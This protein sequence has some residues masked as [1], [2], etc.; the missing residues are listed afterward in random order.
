VSACSAITQG[1]EESKKDKVNKLSLIINFEFVH[2]I[3]KIFNFCYLIFFFFFLYYKTLLLLQPLRVCLLLDKLAPHRLPIIIIISCRRIIL[4]SLRLRCFGHFL[5][6]AMR[7]GLRYRLWSSLRSHTRSDGGLLLGGRS[8]FSIIVLKAA[9]CFS[10]TLLATLSSLRV[11]LRVS[12]SKS[13]SAMVSRP[14]VWYF[15]AACCARTRNKRSSLVL[16]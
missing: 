4:L 14:A 6:G 8:F 5:A 7:G 16:A 10:S 9:R 1:V 11:L 12:P 3:N 2:K 13:L 15:R